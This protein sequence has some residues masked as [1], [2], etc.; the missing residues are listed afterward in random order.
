M[1]RWSRGLLARVGFSPQVRRFGIHIVL[2]FNLGVT[3]VAANHGRSLH[4]AR[5][6]RHLSDLT[7]YESPLLASLGELPIEPLKALL[8]CVQLAR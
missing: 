5:L 8:L 1:L 3:L 6:S 2:V 7:L 4:R